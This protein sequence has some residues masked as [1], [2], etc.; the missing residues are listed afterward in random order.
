MYKYS[1]LDVMPK[2]RVYE[3]KLIDNLII[4]RMLS[5]NNMNELFRMLSETNYSKNTSE[6][7]DHLNYEKILMKELKNLF[8]EMSYIL[9]NSNLID[10]F[11]LKYFYNNLKVMLKS[12]F[13]NINLSNLIF[14]FNSINNLG[15]YEALYNDNYRYLNERIKNIIKFLVNDFDHNR[16]I[17]NID[18][19]LDKFMFEDLKQKVYEIGDNFLINYADKLIDIFNIKTIFRIK[20]LKLDKKILGSVV[21]VPGS[22][23]LEKIKLL[24]LESNDNLLIRFSDIE[25]YKYIKNG[26]EKFINDDDVGLLEIEL[27][28]YL[29]NFLKNQKIYTSGLSPI[30]GYINAKETEIRNVRLIIMGKINNIPSETI[31]GRLILGY[32]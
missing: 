12:K 32:V 20:K 19:M 16:D 6:V 11:T 21:C 18:I 10:V 14:E 22:I 26:I 24:F 5:T 17:T 29:M 31:K 13:L 3:K 2:I 25:I 23:D 1:Y 15:I 4:D 7:I 8:N 27:D 28:N 9:S 30:I